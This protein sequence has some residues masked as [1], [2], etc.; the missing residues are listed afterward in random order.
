MNTLE[1][2]TFD[3]IY[4]KIML[5]LIANE[6]ILYDQYKLYSLVLDKFIKNDSNYVP[7]EFKYK[8]FI[9]IRQ[10]SLKDDNIK[11]FKQDNIYQVIYNPSRDVKPNLVS[12]YSEWIDGPQLNNFIINNNIDL[13]FQDPESGNTIYHDVLSDNNCENVKK[14]LETNTMNY[15]IKN[16]YNKTPIE[17]IKNI[18]VAIL[19]INDLNNKINQLEEKI[20]NLSKHICNFDEKVKKI[21]GRVGSFE[22]KI[23]IFEEIKNENENLLCSIINFFDANSICIIIVAIICYLLIK[24]VI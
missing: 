16:N 12:Y 6:G 2:V 17:C 11:V 18:Q 15:N 3:E 7:P 9:I 1:I 19:V 20:N 8:F 13:N 14:L 5:I 23:N 4:N 22:E 21:N 10:L 24:L